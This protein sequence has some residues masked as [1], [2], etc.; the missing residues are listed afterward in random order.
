MSAQNRKPHLLTVLLLLLCIS[1]SGAKPRRMQ[2]MQPGIWGS[3]HISLEVS[4]DSARVEYD[5]AR[6]TINGP[7]TLDRRGRFN[8]SG[9]HIREH[10][11]PVRIMERP[12]SQPARYTGTTDGRTMSLT[13]TLPETNEVI[14]TFVLVRGNSGRVYK[15]R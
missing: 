5:C 12:K 2:R 15:C 9:T 1:P 10:G 6:G 11:G 4:K 14:G 8:L 13:V 3:D 7:L